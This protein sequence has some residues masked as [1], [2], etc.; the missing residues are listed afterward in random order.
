MRLRQLM[1][2]AI[3]FCQALWAQSEASSSVQTKQELLR[4]IDQLVEQNRRI[5]QQNR[6][7]L[8]QINSLRQSFANQSGTAQPAPA[9]IAPSPAQPGPAGTVRA[10]ESGKSS[11][12]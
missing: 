7:L 6:Q 12:Q 5:E 10:Q 11:T 8:D 2:I 9:Q 4:A 3:L 1:A